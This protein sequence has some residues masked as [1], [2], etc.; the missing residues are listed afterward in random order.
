MIACFDLT[1]GL[2]FHLSAQYVLFAWLCYII[3]S[4]L[5]PL[6]FISSIFALGW[7]CL[8]IGDFFTIGSYINI[9][10]YH[11]LNE[12]GLSIAALIEAIILTAAL[13]WKVHKINKETE[14]LQREL[15]CSRKVMARTM[16][17]VINSTGENID[18]IQ[19]KSLYHTAEEAG[20]DWLF[21]SQEKGSKYI[22]VIVGDVTDHGMSSAM[23]TSLVRG[24][25]TT[26][27]KV[28]EQFNWDHELIIK[29]LSN[30]LNHAIYQTGQQLGRLMTANIIL[31]KPD[32]DKGWFLNAGHPAAFIKSCR[33]SQPKPLYASGSILGL[34]V[35]PSF[36]VKE[37]HFPAGA[38]LL[39]YTDGIIE[40]EGSDGSS[41]SLKQLSKLFG[42][43]KDSEELLLRIEQ[44]C[45]KLWDIQ[46]PQ[47]DISLLILEREIKKIA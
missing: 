31:L 19:V 45:H 8:L 42:E 17:Q 5:F 30:N 36:K 26:T 32:E 6:R 35:N 29:Q 3:I 11:P 20:G 24:V 14:R 12:W 46:S 23:I 10:P 4:N 1:I 22:Y 7:S 44:R 47:D 21:V 33:K 34:S 41:L 18:S 28:A 27:Q 9:I 16:Q 40:Q 25:V 2:N 15:D 13:G 38:Q 43:P 37:F 39:C